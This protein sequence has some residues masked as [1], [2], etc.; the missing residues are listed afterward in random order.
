MRCSLA[1]SNSKSSMHPLSR[2]SPPS[3]CLSSWHGRR[4]GREYTLKRYTR[5]ALFANTAK[6]HWLPPSSL[7]AT[8]AADLCCRNHCGWAPVAERAARRGP[9]LP[10]GGGEA[11]LAFRASILYCPVP[12]DPMQRCVAS[13]WTRARILRG[14]VPYT[15]HV[16]MLQRDILHG[17]AQEFSIPPQKWPGHSSRGSTTRTPPLCP[18]RTWGRARGCA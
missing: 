12:L 5:A 1:T 17:R 2:C 10:R 13:V 4:L 14:S 7:I 16:Q 18:T 15:C 3:S 11:C 8:P 9:D 6:A